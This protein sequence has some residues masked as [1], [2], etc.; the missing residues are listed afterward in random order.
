MASN[1]CF[2][3]QRHA[4]AAFAALSVIEPRDLRVRRRSAAAPSPGCRIRKP[5]PSSAAHSRS[6]M[7]AVVAEQK[8]R[9][10]L[11]AREAEMAAVRL[12]ADPRQHA[13]QR[14]RADRDQ[15]AAQQPRPKR[16]R[17]SDDGDGDGVGAA[18]RRAREQQRHAFHGEEHQRREQRRRS[19]SRWRRRARPRPPPRAP[20]ETRAPPRADR[21]QEAGERERHPE[22]EMN[23]R[24]EQRAVLDVREVEAGEHHGE[25]PGPAP[26]RRRAEQTDRARHQAAHRQLHVGDPRQRTAV[27]TAA[28]R[29]ASGIRAEASRPTAPTGPFVARK[30][31]AVST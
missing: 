9:G 17:R 27:R 12:R 26:E 22:R 1:G 20:S 10:R 25:E 15:R 11:V 7:L 29:G 14:R 19:S 2:T 6:R 23:L 4:S 18:R 30:L 5:W 3:I 16:A 31:R 28:T 8:V 13:E 21:A 24:Q